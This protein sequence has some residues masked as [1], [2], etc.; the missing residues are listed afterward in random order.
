LRK[1][2][3]ELHRKLVDAERRDYERLRGRLSDADFLAVMVSNRDFSWLGALTTLIVNLEEATRGTSPTALTKECLA[4]IRKLVTPGADGGEFNR[5][6]QV[7][8]RNNDEILGAHATVLCALE[9]SE[10]AFR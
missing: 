5:K 8:L 7:I 4:Q 9:A 10:A 2:L 3:V 6:Y 1:A